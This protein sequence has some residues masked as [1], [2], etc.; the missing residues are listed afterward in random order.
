MLEYLRRLHE[1]AC[2]RGQQAYLVGGFLRDFLLGRPS[3][4]VDLVVSGRGEEVARELARASGGSFVPLDPEHDIS[5]VVISGAAGTCQFDITGLG[6]GDL[7]SDLR[8][9]D[10]TINALALPLGDF[11]AACPGEGEGGPLP[12]G[13]FPPGGLLAS[14]I[15]PLGG[16]DDLRR[17]L[18]RA[19]G[20]RSIEDDPLRALRAARLT[21]QLGFCIEPGTVRLIRAMPVPVSKAAPERIWEELVNIFLLPAARAIIDLLDR[22]L[23][24][25]EQIFPEIALMQQNV[26]AHGLKTLQCFEEIAGAVTC[27]AGAS[28]PLALP[29]GL[30]R[31]AGQLAGY[32][33]APLTRTRSRLPVIKLA[34]LFHNAGGL[35]ARATSDG[36]RLT[37]RSSR[38][39]CTPLADAIG[40][41]LRLSSREV[42]LLG[43]LV[44][45]HADAFLLY[46][47]RPVSGREIYHFFRRLGDEVPGCLLLSLASIAASR[48]AAGALPEVLDYQEFIAVLLQRYF[49]D[50][51][52]FSRSRPLLN[53]RDV[54]RLLNIKPSPLVGRL[55][56]ELAAAR[57]AGEVQCREEAEE[58]IKAKA[59]ELL[60]PGKVGE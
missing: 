53:G 52:L 31:L 24:V 11:L 40:R 43:T 60:P 56:E 30:M 55:L 27:G 44:Q 20:P 42:D 4:D 51:A 18:I 3:R 49:E 26:R 15:D 37:T 45:G 36:E 34:C 59:R 58:F 9:R 12:A 41:R 47:S 32:L 35:E 16:L 6:D 2:S 33:T 50:P 25:L 57:A 19:C 14:L 39:A 46:K 54:L 22:E 13:P 17:G 29:A 21:G 1:I 10:F 7:I 38:P 8:R 48:L 23:G 28:A 5:R